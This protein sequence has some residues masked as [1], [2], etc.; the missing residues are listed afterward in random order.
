MIDGCP[1]VRL[2]VSI[3]SYGS[4]LGLLGPTVSSLAVAAE[5]LGGNTEERVR[6][7]II[8]NGP[9]DPGRASGLAQLVE[10]WAGGATLIAGHGNVGYGRGH[11]LAIADLQVAYHLILNPDVELA[12]DA[13][14]QALA[15]MDAHP[16]CGLLSPAVFDEEGRLQYLCKRRPSV[17]DLLLRGF[18]P[19]W[20]RRHFKSR[21][22]RYEMRDHVNDHDLVWDPPI[23]SGCFMLFRAEILKVLGGF[24]PR[25][26]LYFEDFDLSL[27][28]ARLA[29]LAYVPQVRI[30]HHGG[31]AARKGLGHVRMFLA[32]AFK[33][34]NRHGLRWV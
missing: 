13:F 32:S 24:D 30:V 20:V 5:A 31:G 2:A 27:R 3:V 21:L 12:P 18:A 29:R 16:E 19:G 6:L 15:F 28:T 14:V 33:F 22:D 26:F 8:D 34:F 1:E 11:N 7:S 23:V 4:D 9:V 25:Y 10:S 17:L